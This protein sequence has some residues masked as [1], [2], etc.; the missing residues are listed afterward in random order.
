MASDA[1]I[2]IEMDQTLLDQLD[3][4]AKKTE[5]S[6]SDLVEEAVRNLVSVS[7]W[8]E[9]ELIKTV[10]MADRGDSFVPHDE[11]VAWVESWGSENELPRPKARSIKDI[12]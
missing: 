2:S 10:E 7:A 6:R 9:K 3:D 11:V 8:Q 12:S 4:M 5:Q 1:T